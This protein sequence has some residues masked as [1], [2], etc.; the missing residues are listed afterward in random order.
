MKISSKEIYSLLKLFFCSLGYSLYHK[1][2]A[3]SLCSFCKIYSNYF[4]YS[5]RFDVHKIYLGLVFVWLAKKYMNW[6]DITY[7]KEVRAV[8]GCTFPKIRLYITSIKSLFLPW[9]L[10]GIV[11]DFC[12]KWFAHSISFQSSQLAIHM[13]FFKPV[14]MLI[15]KNLQ[16]KK[17]NKLHT[18]G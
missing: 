8:W 2:R 17:L 4:H 3:L 5:I 11:C 6:S 12:T 10:Q 1:N 14:L 7:Y 15:K 18:S 9:C 16:K 13:L